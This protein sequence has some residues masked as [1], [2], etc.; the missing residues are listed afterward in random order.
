MA[1]EFAIGCYLGVLANL[2]YTLIYIAIVGNT[3]DE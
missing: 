1:H 3:E 2:V